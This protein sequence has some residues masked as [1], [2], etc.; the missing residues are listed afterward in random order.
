MKTNRQKQQT[1]KKLSQF[2]LLKLEQL[3][4]VSGG[5]HCPTVIPP[6]EQPVPPGAEIP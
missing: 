6:G 1:L 2:Q 4:G 5:G 3:D